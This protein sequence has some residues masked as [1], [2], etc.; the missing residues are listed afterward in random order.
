M[1]GG[2]EVGDLALCVKSSRRCPDC[3]CDGESTKGQVRLVVHTEIIDTGLVLFLDGLRL[4]AAICTD[5]AAHI[6]YDPA[7]FRKIPPHTIDSE[8][9]ETIGLLNK[10][11]D[12]VPA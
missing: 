12:E 10:Q 11:P 3:G 4:D 7:C 5:G 6:G 8:D 1:S 2:W 9:R